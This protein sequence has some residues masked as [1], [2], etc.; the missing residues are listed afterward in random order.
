M[1]RKLIPALAAFFIVLNVTIVAVVLLTE[2]EP[3]QRA[4]PNPNGYD[5]FVSAGKLVL[6]GNVDTT[7]LNHDELAA[8]V[9]S[10]RS[11]LAAVRAGLTHGS[12][13]P[14]NYSTTNKDVLLT[15]YA[16][17]KNLSLVITAEGRLAEMEG[18][19]NDAAKIYLE[20]AR[21]GQDSSRGGVI[22]S[23]LV[24][25]GCE[26]IAINCLRPLNNQLDATNSRALAKGLETLDDREDTPE[27]TLRQEA[28]WAR[29]TYGIRGQI[30]LLFTYQQLKVTR[31]T[32]TA[33]DQNLMR[34][35]R[36]MMLL[37]ATHAYEL[38]KG[39]PAATA[40]DLVPDYLKAIPKD[41]V[42]G[43]DLNLGR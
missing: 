28:R 6:L 36:E 27:Q 35:R 19:T 13:V 8:L 40:A 29:K 26:N 16:A 3:P 1:K 4:M 2:S 30:A 17:F 33:K 37:F 32:F 9:A 41:L 11:A 20:A 31:D 5:D 15:D 14:D 21:F 43:Q 23:R 38:E 10:N 12:L 7:K 22:M 24:G 39:K 25:V 18:R 42:T 34:A